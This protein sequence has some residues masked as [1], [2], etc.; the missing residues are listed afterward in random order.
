MLSPKKGTNNMQL[1]SNVTTTTTPCFHNKVWQVSKQVWK[2]SQVRRGPK[3]RTE[4]SWHYIVVVSVTFTQVTA[5]VMCHDCYIFW[6]FSSRV[7]FEELCVWSGLVP[8][9]CLTKK[10]ISER[11]AGFFTLSYRY[12]HIQKFMLKNVSSIFFASL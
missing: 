2:K 12:E 3:A 5:A 11:F 8:R 4:L 9:E 7:V 6:S 10:A 1:P